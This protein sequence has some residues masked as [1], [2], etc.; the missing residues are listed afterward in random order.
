MQQFGPVRSSDRLPPRDTVA[1]RGSAEH[2]RP[3]CVAPGARAH[4]LTTDG[5]ASVQIVNPTADDAN[6]IYVQTTTTADGGTTADIKALPLGGGAPT[7]ILS[8][9]PTELGLRRGR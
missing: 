7:T 1:A 4:L 6:V 5:D 3:G 2:G 8:D 9:T